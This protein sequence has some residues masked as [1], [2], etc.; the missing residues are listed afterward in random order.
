MTNASVSHAKNNLSALLKEVRGGATIVI[1]DHG[2]P[3][4]QLGPVATPRGVPP[5]AIELAAQGLLAL[6]AKQPSARWLDLPLP[7]LKPGADPI[8]L[9]IDERGGGW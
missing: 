7:K 9:V 8:E 2:V 6:P 4:A 1:T 5:R 3:V